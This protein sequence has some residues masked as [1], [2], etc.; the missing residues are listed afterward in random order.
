MYYILHVFFPLFPRRSAK[1]YEKKDPEPGVKGE[2]SNPRKRPKKEQDGTGPQPSTGNTGRSK[3]PKKAKKMI[4]FW[5]YSPDLPRGKPDF[6]QARTC[7]GRAYGHVAMKF[8]KTTL[9]V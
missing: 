9:E 7:A 3:K 2:P 8:Q 1:K 5:V 6:V 4:F